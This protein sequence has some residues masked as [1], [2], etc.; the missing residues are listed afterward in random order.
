MFVSR[1]YSEKVWTSHDRR[2][3]QARALKEKL[4][5]I[6]PARFDDTPIPGLPNTIHYIDLTRTTRGELASIAS[7]KVGCDVRE[8][9]LPP[10][11]DRLYERLGRTTRKPSLLLNPSLRRS[12]KHFVG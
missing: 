6:L 12:F 3:A 4:E 1:E 10:V 2:S 8:N 11:L 7:E 5:Y 9:Y